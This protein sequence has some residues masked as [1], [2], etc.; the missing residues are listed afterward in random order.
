MFDWRARKKQRSPEKL[1][2]GVL[3]GFSLSAILILGGILLSGGDLLRFINIGSLLIVGGGTVGATLV[4][5]TPADF[6]HAFQ[7]AR[8]ALF[9][10]KDD[11]AARIRYFV[12]LSHSVRSQGRIG[13]LEAEASRVNDP[14]LQFAL[15]LSAD[16]Q[17]VAD[18]R[19]ILETEMRI[20]NERALKAVQVFE[21]MGN[22][23][24]ALGLIGTIIGLIQ[25]L[26]ALDNPKNVGPAMATALITTL[27][28]AISSNI[29]LIPLAGKLRN[30]AEE[31][32]M[33]KTITIEGV[34]SVGNEENPML[35]EQRLQ[36]FKPAIGA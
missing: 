12:R 24:P 9:G 2:R 23:A 31:E 36:S 1:D 22:F 35:V 34:I 33:K 18:I 14:F 27:Y 26:G 16:G 20:A 19:R 13:A 5:F 15:E 29:I 32:A 3:Y 28:G 11:F 17:P 8:D 4:H 10:K 6:T 30:R 7:T 25:M 21:T